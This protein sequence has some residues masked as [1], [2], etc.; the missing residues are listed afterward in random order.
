MKTLIKFS[1][2]FLLVAIALLALSQLSSRNDLLGREPLALCCNNGFCDDGQYANCATSS[3]I[4]S[5]ALLGCSQDATYDCKKCIDLQRQDQVCGHFNRDAYCNNNGTPYYVCPQVSVS[6]SGPSQLQPNQTGTFTA[7]VS[8]GTS[9]FSYQWYKRIECDYRLAGPSGKPGPRAPPCGEWFAGGTNSPTYQTAAWSDFS[10]RVDISDY[11]HQGEEPRTASAQHYVTVSGGL[12][13]SETRAPS[14]A[15]PAEATSGEPLSSS[16]AGSGL[17]MR[18]YPNPFNPT[19]TINFTL[20]QPASVSLAVYNTR[21]QQVRGLISGEWLSAGTHT[22]AW[23]GKN[24]DGNEVA[25]G[26]YLCR[27]SAGQNVKIIRLL[28][29]R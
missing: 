14:M 19:T 27:L 5:E 1:Y 21:G 28:L 29:T 18:A 22:V 13:K 6:I 8:G 4:K 12:A 17:Q 3:T 9:P 24:E 23:E 16:A 11:C 15:V 20:L 2:A 25:S 7:N 10:V 26:M